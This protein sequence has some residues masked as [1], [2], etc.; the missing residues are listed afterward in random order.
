MS[1]EPT[2]GE[3]LPDDIRHE[4]SVDRL[5][6]E[7]DVLR[8]ELA[9]A[10]KGE[11]YRLAAE[12]VELRHER[13]RADVLI[14][15]LRA[16]ASDHALRLNEARACLREALASSGGMRAMHV[17]TLLDLLGVG[18]GSERKRDAAALADAMGGAA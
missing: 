17:R 13:D 15:G 18:H 3:E 9:E 16:S 6:Y 4:N 2:I 5:E 1:H 7:N 8:A 11:V 12:V 14:A 10:R